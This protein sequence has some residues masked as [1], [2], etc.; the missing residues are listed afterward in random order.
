M[1]AS[2]GPRSAVTTAESSG[3]SGQAPVRCYSAESTLG[4]RFHIRRDLG[5]VRIRGFRHRCVFSPH[6]R[7]ARRSLDAHRLGPGCARAGAV[8]ALRSQGVI[9]HSDRGCQYLSIRYTERLEEAGVEPSVG[10]VGDSYDNAL[11]E[12]VIGLFKTEV[13]HRRGPWRKLDDVEYATLEW[14]DWFNNRRLLEPIGNIP[15]AEF[16]LMYYRQQDESA[17]RGLTQTGVSGNP[18]AVHH[19]S[20][21]GLVHR[22][23]M[24]RCP[25]QRKKGRAPGTSSR[26]NMTSFCVRTGPRTNGTNA[27]G[28]CGPY[29]PHWSA[30]ARHPGPARFRN[31]RGWYPRNAT[32]SGGKVRV[33]IEWTN[34][35]RT[36]VT[37]ARTIEPTGGVHVPNLQSAGT[38][39]HRLRFQVD[40]EST[41][42]GMA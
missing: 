31:S 11:A 41:T 26:P 40:V 27:G 39:L 2:A 42:G 5:G 10:S 4:R 12:S 37:E 24:S 21:A 6:H 33:V 34:A 25:A 8:G 14:V 30:P 36:A 23:S 28:H 22:Q 1:G 38:A 32:K 16:E 17:D 35:L 18:G 3:G 19:R 7:L 9:H 29:I 15:P 20:R 13:I